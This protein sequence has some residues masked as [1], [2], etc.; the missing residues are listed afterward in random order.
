VTERD[1]E[2]SAAQGKDYA[3]RPASYKGSLSLALDRFTSRKKSRSR[4]PLR[5]P[6]RSDRGGGGGR[7]ERDSQRERRDRDREDAGRSDVYES[8]HSGHADESKAKYLKSRY[9]DASNT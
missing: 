9:G 7:D 3:Q 6:N 5:Q 4:S 8:R 2:K 1:R